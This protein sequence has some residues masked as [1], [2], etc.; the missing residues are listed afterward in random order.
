MTPLDL[1]L[2]VLLAVAVFGAITSTQRTPPR[3]L[4]RSAATR[5]RPTTERRDRRAADRLADSVPDVVDLLA[6]AAAAGCNVRLAIE[7]VA[8]ALR[9]DAP[10]ARSLERAL[11][12]ATSGGMRLADAITSVPFDHPDIR[13]SP[14]AADA[15]RPV[16]LLLAD[17]ER[18]GTPLAPALERVGDQ[19]RAERRRRAETR[20]RRLPVRLLLPLVCCILPAFALLTVA[21]LLVSGVQALTTHTDVHE[22][23]EEP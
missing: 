17:A 12:A 9:D 5:T 14:L 16:C 22:L 1:A 3:R 10:A 4:S 6:V 21:P 7:A 2:V 13:G 15:L 8:H 20:A 19:L 23:Q 18:Y 11:R